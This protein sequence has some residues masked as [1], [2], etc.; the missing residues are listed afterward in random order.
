MQGPEAFT[1]ILG[2]GITSGRVIAQESTLGASERRTLLS[3]PLEGPRA[4]ALQGHHPLGELERS[5][6]C[7]VPTV[8]WLVNLAGMKRA[9]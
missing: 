9:Y 5:Y 7:L 2:L 1:P 3:K 8:L 6:P 4:A